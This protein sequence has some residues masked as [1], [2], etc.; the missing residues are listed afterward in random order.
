M[1]N[2]LE[3]IRVLDFGRYLAGPFCGALLADL[4]ADVI[5]IDKVGGS[6]DRNYAPITDDGAGALFM[7][8]NRNKR[9]LTLNPSTPAGREITRRLVASADVLIANMAPATLATLGFDYATLSAINPRIVLTTISAFGSGG[10]ASDRVGFDGIGQAVSGAIDSTGFADMPVKPNVPYVDFGT[11]LSSALGTVAALFHR[12]TT[13]RGQ[14]VEGSL[15]ATA[16]TFLSGLLIDEAVLGRSRPRIGSRNP[17]AGPSDVF[18]TLDGAV[19]LQIIGDPLFKRW[20]K[21]VEKP[22]LA[23][24]ARFASDQLRGENGEYLSQ[25]MAVWCAARTTDEV[26]G[27]MDTHKL[28]VGRVNSLGD[29]LADPHVAAI[30]LLREVSYP[31]LDRPV[32][33]VATIMRMSEQQRDLRR[34][35]T[36]G[37]HTDA[38]LAELGYGAQD[39]ATFRA[40]DTV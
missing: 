25:L 18:R 8:A 33:L 32:P 35:P 10:P 29:A 31:G 36:S 9:S 16:Y 22:E 6:E 15:L 17:F 14:H 21:M 4:G 13:G 1:P 30:G 37:E 2:I 40:N 3:G 26:I 27:S 20:C 38:V 11:A 34:P 23:H 39:I 7:Q 12:T 5:R 28:P 24:D 19:F